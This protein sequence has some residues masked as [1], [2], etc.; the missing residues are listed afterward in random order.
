MGRSLDIPGTA[1]VQH[2]SS[3]WQGPHRLPHLDL[4]L[5]RWGLANLQN[6]LFRNIHLGLRLNNQTIHQQALRQVLLHTNCPPEPPDP[7]QSYFES[8]FP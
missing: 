3:I 7:P 2:A 5:G 4:D 1:S 8:R 6:N